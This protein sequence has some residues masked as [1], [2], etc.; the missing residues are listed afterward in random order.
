MAGGR[1]EGERREGLRHSEGVEAVREHGVDVAVGTGPDGDGAGTG[2]FQPE[3]S[4]YR[5]PSRKRPRHER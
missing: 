2:G 4:P 5:L 1:G 3:L